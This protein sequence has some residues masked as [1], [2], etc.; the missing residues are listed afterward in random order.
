[1]LHSFGLAATT[2]KCDSK[3]RLGFSPVPFKR[4]TK[5]PL[6]GADSKIS[7]SK[8]SSS[9]TSAR[10]DAASVSFPGGFVVFIR[11]RSPRR[12]VTSS[13]ISL[14]SRVIHL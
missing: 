10:Y 3:R 11:I 2:S 12:A 5:F 4:V 6:P 7:Q 1:M 8:P 13:S 9:K 14:R